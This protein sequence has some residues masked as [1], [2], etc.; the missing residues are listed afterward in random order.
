MILNVA[1]SAGFLAGPRLNTYYATKNYVL[2]FS[3]A[4]YEELRR[5]KSNVHISILCTNFGEKCFWKYQEDQKN[6]FDPRISWPSSSCQCV[7]LAQDR[8][9][10]PT[11]E[12][13]P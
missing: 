10:Y 7:R 8:D 5:A 4:I 6:A 13:P 9:P 3:M 2:K 1:S 11:P 12:C